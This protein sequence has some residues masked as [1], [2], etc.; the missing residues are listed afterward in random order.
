MDSSYCRVDKSTRLTRHSD[1]TLRQNKQNQYHKPAESPSSTA[2]PK[3]SAEG[4]GKI[5]EGGLEEKD[6]E[7]WQAL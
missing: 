5:P 4:Q 6:F 7:G 3:P 2:G 1:G